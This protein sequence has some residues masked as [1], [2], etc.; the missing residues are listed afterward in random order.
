MVREES[1]LEGIE[2]LVSFTTVI[3]LWQ[4]DLPEPELVLHEVEVVALEERKDLESYRIS[5]ESGEE[6]PRKLVFTGRLQNTQ[7]AFVHG[8]SIK[9]QISNLDT[10]EIVFE[11]ARSELQIVPHSSFEFHTFVDGEL[12]V[13]GYYLVTYIIESDGGSWELQRKIF[14]ESNL[15]ERASNGQ[16]S[17][18]EQRSLAWVYMI[19]LVVMISAGVGLSIYWHKQSLDLRK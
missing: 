15:L 12:F 3:L 10:G 18:E 9:S 1:Q 13:D 6:N 5:I 7:A 11:E 19:I 16:R 8:V 14:V 2:L 4:G 17:L